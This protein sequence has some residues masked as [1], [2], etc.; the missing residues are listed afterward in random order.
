VLKSN[1]NSSLSI[2]ILDFMIVGLMEL[3]NLTA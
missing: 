2:L 1:N 3:K